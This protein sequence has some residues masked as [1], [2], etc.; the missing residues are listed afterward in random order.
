MDNEN[1]E[2]QLWTIKR[3]EIQIDRYLKG[4]L[5]FDNFLFAINNIIKSSKHLCNGQQRKVNS[6]D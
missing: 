1:Y 6:S 4:N 5:D 2:L 3:L